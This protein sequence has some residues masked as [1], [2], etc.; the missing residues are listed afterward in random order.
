MCDATS[1]TTYNNVQNWHRELTR[2]CGEGIPIVLVGNKCDVEDRVLRE[3][4]ITFHR[5]KN[6]RYFDI[7]AKS[8]HNFEKPF[9]WLARTLLRCVALAMLR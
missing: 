4:D 7:S 1:R 8:G 3:E 9:E 2:V 6:L 5:K